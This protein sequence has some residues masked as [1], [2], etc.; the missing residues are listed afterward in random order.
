MFSFFILHKDRI[1]CKSLNRIEKER[2]VY[3][4]YQTYCKYRLSTKKIDEMHK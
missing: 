3:L 1:I 4:T 2:F